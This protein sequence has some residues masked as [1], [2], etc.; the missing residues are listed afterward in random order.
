MPDVTLPLLG[1]GDLQFGG[2]NCQRGWDNPGLNS[3]VERL[4][5][6]SS[7]S[8]CSQ[9]PPQTPTVRR[10]K[11]QRELIQ[12]EDGLSICVESDCMMTLQ[13]I[14]L[15]FY[16][17]APPVQAVNVPCRNSYCPCISLFLAVSNKHSITSH[18][19]TTLSTAHSQ[20]SQQ[21]TLNTLNSTLSTAHSLRVFPNHN[22]LKKTF[23]LSTAQQSKLSTNPRQPLAVCQR[24][25]KE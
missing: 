11:K 19:N 9:C 16:L 8:Y 1:G 25:N 6:P 7:R 12:G 14:W 3:R 23:S 17:F 20:H 22:L 18:L 2:S 15:F 4:W 24:H 5:R 13:D 10:R 21:H